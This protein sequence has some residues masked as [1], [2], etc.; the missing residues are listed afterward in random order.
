MSIRKIHVPLIGHQGAEELK[1]ASETAVRV[2]LTFGRDLA[3]H[4]EVCCIATALHDPDELLAAAYP[5]T[6]I[7]VLLS[8]VKKQNSKR[9]WLARS[10]FDQLAAGFRPQRDRD[11]D[12]EPVFSAEFLEI[13]GDIPSVAAE[14][15]KLA[16][17]SV[18]ASKPKGQSKQH[19]LLLQTL[20]T[21]TGRPLM[22]VPEDCAEVDLG[23][24]AIA[25]N[26]TNES[27]RAVAMTMDFIRQAS[28]VLIIT[29]L[30]DGALTS[31]PQALAAYLH[32][33][34]VQARVVE[35]SVSSQG[36]ADVL[37]NEADKANS[38]LLIMGA[39]T[40]GRLQRILFGGATVGA[41]AACPLP[42]LLVD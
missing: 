5:D 8:E 10:L 14:R 24:I 34:G 39:Y 12:G 26:D 1:V 7:Q 17:L 37:F 2:G 15:G 30:E 33:H 9:F 22:V 28:D 42:L 6:A 32:W 41:L 21:D 38:G 11:P 27:A 36:V 13:S 3:A 20:L 18:I 23:K 31:G 16:D 25:W 19:D 29:V 35:V 4:V 40:R